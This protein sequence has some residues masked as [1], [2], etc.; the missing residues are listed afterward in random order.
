MTDTPRTDEREA[1][2]YGLHEGWGLA[3]ARQL[4]RELASEKRKL[5]AIYDLV[6]GSADG[7]E[8]ATDYEKLCNRI[9]GI[10]AP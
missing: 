3:L 10:I 9:V 2:S 5:A 6:E 7:A 1:K 4:E 8:D